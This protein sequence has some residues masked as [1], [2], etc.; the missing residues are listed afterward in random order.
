[1]KVLMLGVYD[2]NGYSRG[3]I[4]WKGLTAN[5]VDVD[6][7]LRTGRAKYFSIAKRLLKKDFDVV[8]VNGKLVLLTAWLLKWWHRKPVVFDVFIS[9]Y[10]TLVFDR[11]IVKEGSLKARLLWWSDKISCMLAD[12]NFLDTQ[13]HIEYFVRTFK[14]DPAKFSIIYIGSDDDVFTFQPMPK[15][16]GTVVYFHGTFIPLHGMDVIVRAA[17][18]LEDDKSIT[19][20]IVGKGQTYEPTRK[21]ADELHVTSINWEP[22]LGLHELPKRMA[23]G[24]ISL[25]NFGASE[26]AK[27]VITHKAFDTISCGRP[28]ITVDTPAHREVFTHGK[29]AWLVPPNNPEA[30]AEA[31]RTLA[32]DRKLRE[33]IAENGHALFAEKYSTKE[34]GQAL[35]GV[36]EATKDLRD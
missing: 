29:T 12:R 6:L 9:D 19:F 21:L 31:I 32:K 15:N 24:D 30:L 28:L 1:M 5:N 20:H 7:F 10:D 14:S 2:I 17:K 18:L 8:L 4:L 13:S 33:T 23:K 22:L 36:L 3:R 26:K 25:G 16:T 34:I 11:K 35:K 27:M